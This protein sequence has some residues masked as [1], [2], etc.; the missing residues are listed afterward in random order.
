MSAPYLIF[1]AHGGI[2]E[3]LARR[4]SAAGHA[5]FLTARDRQSIAG[6]ADEL[7]ARSASCDVLDEGQLQAV[8]EEADTGDGIR[9][10]AFCVGN[11]VLKSLR[12]ATADDFLD[13]Y[14]LNAL[15]PALAIK[16]AA[17]PLKQANGS[18]VLF[19]TVA[20]QQ[21]FNN[22]SVIAAAKG[23]VEALTRSLAT[24]LAPDV[25]VNCIAPSVHRTGIAKSLTGNEQLAK[26]LAAMHPIPRLGEPD[27]AAAAAAYLLGRD[28]GWVTG[29]VLGVD[30]GRG[31]LRGKGQ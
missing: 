12:S 25:R 11:I 16:A 6:L 19:S 30:G 18:V 24:E 31:V 17:K 28:A 13:C 4:L 22:H 10:L 26:G 27:D 15:A 7:D 3:A 21:G 2:G 29:Q 23:A 14:R 8:V 9:G 1:G 5:L 20:V